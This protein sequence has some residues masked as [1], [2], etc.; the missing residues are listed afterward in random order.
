MRM[1]RCKVCS[2]IEE[3][4]K[5]LVPKFEFFV[6]HAWLRKCITIQ[7]EIIIVAYF[8]NSTNAHVKKEK[9]YATIGFDI[10]FAQIVNVGKAEKNIYVQFIAM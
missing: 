6:K 10:I 4:E 9:L 8:L 1:M 2:K 3:K 5:L 7:R